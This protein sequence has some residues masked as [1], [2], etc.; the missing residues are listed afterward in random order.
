MKLPDLPL[1]MRITSSAMILVALGALTLLFVEEAHLRAVYS[2]QRRAQLEKAFRTN[3]LR[4]TQAF[5]TLRRDVQFLAN[6]PP[7]SGIMR[8]ARNKGYDARDGN[9]RQQWEVRLQQILAPFLLANP[10]YH[11]ASYIEVADQNRDILRLTNHDEQIKVDTSS[12]PHSKA[13]IDNYLATLALSPGQVHLSNFDLHLGGDKSK[14]HEFSIIR[15]SVP[16]FDSEGKVFGL[17]VLSMDISSL[18]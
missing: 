13:E 9:T 18:L 14:H 7:V 10:D 12:R 1:S 4:L 3:E 11:E 15:A 6:T 2:G 5:V 16:V 8:A 17:I